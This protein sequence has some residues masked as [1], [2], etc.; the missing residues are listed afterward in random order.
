MVQKSRGPRRKSRSKMIAR[1]K[2]TVNQYLQKFEV[3]EKVHYHLQPN[4]KGVGYP[5]IMF[6]GVTGEV[7][8]KRG[9]AYV[10]RF[11][12]KDATKT[13]VTMPVHLRKAGVPKAK[14]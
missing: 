4:V 11:M 13:L 5:Y 8:A 9:K 1:Y 6:K 14:A 12:D 7:V 3:G 10:V 2:P